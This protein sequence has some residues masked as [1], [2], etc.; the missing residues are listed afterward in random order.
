LSRAEKA[1]ADFK[2]LK[3]ALGKEESKT[4]ALQNKVSLLQGDLERSEKRIEEVCEQ[5]TTEQITHTLAIMTL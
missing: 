1:E 2:V 5:A 4:A 3:E